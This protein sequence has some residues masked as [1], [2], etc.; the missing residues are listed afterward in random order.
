MASRLRPVRYPVLSTPLPPRPSNPRTPLR[1]ND[2]HD[3]GDESRRNHAAAAASVSSKPTLLRKL[4]APQLHREN[5][6]ALQAVRFIVQ[7]NFFLDEGGAAS[8][9]AAEPQSTPATATV[10]SPTG[11]APAATEAVEAS[12]KTPGVSTVVSSPPAAASP[13]VAAVDASAVAADKG[14]A[15]ESPAK[16]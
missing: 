14:D 13:L 10:S 3:D 7:S 9:A 11:A 8:A 16:R 15:D 12:E 1:R 4:L 2:V 6:I 5:S